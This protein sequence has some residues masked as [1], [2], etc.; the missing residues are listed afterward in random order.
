[1]N[2]FHK[3]NLIRHSTSSDHI[4]VVTGI[5]E[6]NP[7]LTKEITSDSSKWEEEKQRGFY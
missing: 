3:F 2:S 5:R 6:K 1:M 7:I 4:L